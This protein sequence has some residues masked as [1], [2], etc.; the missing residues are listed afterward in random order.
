MCTD[1]WAHG[2]PVAL[3]P[4]TDGLQCGGVFCHVLVTEV[5]LSGGGVG[6]LCTSHR[7]S[8]STLGDDSVLRSCLSAEPR[9]LAELPVMVAPA[10]PP[11]HDPCPGL[12]SAVVPEIWASLGSRM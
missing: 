3:G 11:Q 5:F 4:K 9:S 2:S 10:P 12:T 8:W 1:C 7:V 6:K